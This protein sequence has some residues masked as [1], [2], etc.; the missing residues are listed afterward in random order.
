MPAAL[1]YLAQR[2]LTEERDGA[3]VLTERGRGGRQGQGL[4][5]LAA[6]RLRRTCSPASATSS[7]ARA[8]TAA[9]SS[10][11]GAGSPK[12]RALI[13]RDDVAP[14]A[15]EVLGGIDFHHV[16]DLGCGNARFL[17]GAAQRFGVTGVGVDLSP[18]ACE[19]AATMIA[20]AELTGKSRRPLRR[21]RR[22]RRDP[23]AGR[24]GP[25]RRALPA[26]RDLRARPRGAR[27]L[28]DEARQA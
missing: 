8:D 26:A 21:R 22:P 4:P 3:F 13:G 15:V 5:R 14:Y 11:P 2:E 1:R 19:D 9:T 16:V 23:R 17:I 6:G 7:P 12:A 10:A 27:R 20:D 24:G 28:P 25:R 18:E